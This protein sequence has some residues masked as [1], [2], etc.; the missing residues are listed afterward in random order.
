[1]TVMPGLGAVVPS[2]VVLVGMTS[3]EVI[4][5]VPATSK[6]TRRPLAL[7]A[8]RSEPVPES[9]RLVT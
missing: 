3:A 8:A 5:I 6:T 2:T 9:L 4:L 7:S 1:M